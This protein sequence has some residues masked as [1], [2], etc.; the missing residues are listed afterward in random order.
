MRGRDKRQGNK[1]TGIEGLRT[2]TEE[3]EVV[4]MTACSGRRLDC[5]FNCAPETGNNLQNGGAG[6]WLKNMGVE[7]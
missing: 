6:K 3:A 2:E 4:F 5:D 1:G 7:K